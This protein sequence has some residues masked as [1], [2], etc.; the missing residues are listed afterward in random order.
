MVIVG[1]SEVI[2]SWKIIATSLPRTSRICFSGI[3]TSSLPSR[4]TDAPDDVADVG[5]QLHDRQPGRAL[6]AAGLSDEA[7]ALALGDVERDPVDGADVRRAKVEF[8]AEVNDLEN[9]GH[10]CSPL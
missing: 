9:V 7:Q 6:A 2:G 5:Q 4:F 8:G 10:G 3:F 1:F